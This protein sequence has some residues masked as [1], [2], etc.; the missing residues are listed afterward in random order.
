MIDKIHIGWGDSLC[1]EYEACESSSLFPTESNCDKCLEIYE[2]EKEPT[3]SEQIATLKARIAELEAKIEMASTACEDCGLT[4]RE[5]L[6]DRVAELES[7]NKSLESISTAS[8]GKRLIQ[9]NEALTD[10]VAELTA[11]LARAEE[12]LDAQEVCAELF[13]TTMAENATLTTK[14][15]ELERLL[16]AEAWTKHRKRVTELEAEVEEQKQ[17]AQ[18]LAEQL[19][20]SGWQYDGRNH[21]AQG[22]IDMARKALED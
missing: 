6:T 8:Y 15:K 4:P 21:D 9:T 14:N 1:G 22:W 3:Y 20:K 18:V 16:K 5:T 11:Q 17:I 2:R 19:H 13:A 12:T 10:R 7:R